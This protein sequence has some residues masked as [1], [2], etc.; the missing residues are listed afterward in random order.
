M[1]IIEICVRHVTRNKN[2]SIISKGKKK[3]KNNY[4]K[5]RAMIISVTYNNN[6]NIT[7]TAHTPYKYLILYV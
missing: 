2:I 6:N 3:K 4:Y 7:K 5:R 1:F